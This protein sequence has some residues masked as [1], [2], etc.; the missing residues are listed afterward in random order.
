MKFLFM[1]K[2]YGGV[3]LALILAMTYNNFTSILLLS[4]MKLV[5]SKRFRRFVR[6]ISDT[7][8]KEIQQKIITILIPPN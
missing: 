7:Q 2:K 5:S 3:R 8:F 1:K 4:Q 6:K